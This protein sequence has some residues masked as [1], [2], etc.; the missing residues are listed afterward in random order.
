MDVESFNQGVLAAITCP[1]GERAP[2]G[3]PIGFTAET[4]EEQDL[5][6]SNAGVAS[7]LLAQQHACRSGWVLKKDETRGDAQALNCKCLMSQRDC[8]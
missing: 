2:V 3:S 4:D 7:A 6:A 8:F 1:E 5:Q